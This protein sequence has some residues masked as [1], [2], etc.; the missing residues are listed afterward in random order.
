MGSPLTNSTRRSRCTRGSLRSRRASLTPILCV[1]RSSS[2]SSSAPR[3][4]PRRPS[5][6][7]TSSDPGRE[8]SPPPPSATRSQ[9]IS[10]KLRSSSRRPST[11]STLA[12]P[13]P[14]PPWN[15]P[16]TSR[17]PEISAQAPHSAELALLPGPDPSQEQGQH[18]DQDPWSPGINILHLTT[19]LY[20]FRLFAL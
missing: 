5:P 19:C 16:P 7:S 10:R 2:V 9:Q 18:S 1:S 8:S 14:A 17:P 6:P 13:L 11:K 15:P 4:E 20:T 12:P 3:T